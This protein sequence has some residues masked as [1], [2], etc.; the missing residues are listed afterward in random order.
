MTG[1][2]SLRLPVPADAAEL[3]RLHVA[4]WRE[5]YAHL[6]PEGFFSDQHYRERR[7]LW[8]R[9]LADDNP[10]LRRMVAQRQG[11]LIGLALAGESFAVEGHG[12]P[13]TLQLFSLYILA[14]E[15]GQGVGQ[16]LLDAVLGHDPAVLWVAR[17]NPRAIAFYRKNHFELDGVSVQDPKVSSI[18]DVRMVR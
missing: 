14:S 5:A 8:D 17:E 9:I 15:Y 7:Q 10:Q 1:R 3:T 16:E 4:T 13:R 18:V 6:L 11:Q 2:F 12:P